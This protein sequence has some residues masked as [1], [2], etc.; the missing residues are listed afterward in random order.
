MR[1]PNL[2]WPA[3]AFLAARLQGRCTT[4]GPR[5]R[6]S[7]TSLGGR[8][9]LPRAVAGDRRADRL[10]ASRGPDG[11]LSDATGATAAAASRLLATARV[12]LS[13]SGREPVLLLDPDQ[14][15]AETGRDA[16]ATLSRIRAGEPVRPVEME[17]LRAVV[18]ARL[19][20]ARR[21][22]GVA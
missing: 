10:R 16:V 9:R 20:E 14:V 6:A 2:G 4:R 11:G 7:L 8:A 19:D 12:A 18:G 5:A 1:A 13:L 22:H 3:R 15:A 21:A 17:R